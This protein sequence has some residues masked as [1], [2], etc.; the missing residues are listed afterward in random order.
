MASRRAQSSL[1]EKDIRRAFDRRLADMF[2]DR[3]YAVSNS[4]G[5]YGDSGRPDK[6]IV[7]GGRY[8]AIEFKSG[9][10]GSNPV[11]GLTPLQ[12]ATLQKIARAGGLCFVVNT[13]PYKNGA[14][15]WWFHGFQIGAV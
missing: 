3:F 11:S 15:D 4:P 8:Y 2:G 6:E 9:R 13:V 5:A 1:S 14:G 7:V 12:L 10:Y